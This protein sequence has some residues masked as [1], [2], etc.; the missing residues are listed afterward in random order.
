MTILLHEFK[1]HLT[2]GFRLRRAFRQSWHKRFIPANRASQKR[3]HIYL[4]ATM[5]R[6]NVPAA[7]FGKKT[8]AQVV[9]LSRPVKSLKSEEWEEVTR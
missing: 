1:K 9:K 5:S 2:E 4:N 3:R 8:M 7:D 6:C